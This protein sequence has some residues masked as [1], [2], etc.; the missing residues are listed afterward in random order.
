V[1]RRGKPKIPTVDRLVRALREAQA[2]A[3][4]INNAE[5]GWYDEVRSKLGR[6]LAA[7]LNDAHH[8]RLNTI[9]HRVLAHEFDA[10]PWEWEAW[11]RGA[12]AQD[13]AAWN[14]FIAAAKAGGKL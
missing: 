13:I 4:M 14:T 6:P 9:E 7:L 12:G 11:A 10:Q 8:Y 3:E 5:L 2:P 1:S